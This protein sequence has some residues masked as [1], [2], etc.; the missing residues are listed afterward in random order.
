MKTWNTPKIEEL[1]I[2]ETAGGGTVKTTHD[3][4]AYVSE[5]GLWVEEYYPISGQPDPSSNV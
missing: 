2:N 3:G 1:K 4:K 5:N